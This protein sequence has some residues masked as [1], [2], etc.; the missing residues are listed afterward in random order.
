MSISG[1]AVIITG[2]SQGL[3]RALAEELASRGARLLLVARHRLALEE[4]VASVR[5]AGGE[6]YGLPYDVADKSAV[7]PLAAAAH[8][9]LGD[10][11]VLV[12][13]ASTLGPVPLRPLLDTDCESL[14]RVLDVNLVGPFRLTKAVAGNMALRGS[15]TLLFIS[16][17]AA[18]EAYP[19]WGAYGVSKAALDHL[20]RSLAAELGAS[21][22]RVLSVDP[23][24]MNTRMHRDALPEADP[25]SLADPRDVAARIASM[26]EG[27][28]GLPNGARLLASAWQKAS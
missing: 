28:D 11:D 12:H 7:Y 19:S 20:A 27:I 25:R 8:A 3:G 16:S 2:A 14:T 17:D 24:E 21:G 4:V 15:G 6:A 9:L 5:R 26:V 23:G 18:I 1:K 13:N 10:I 22:I